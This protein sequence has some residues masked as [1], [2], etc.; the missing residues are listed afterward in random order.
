LF[1]ESIQCLPLSSKNTVFLPNYLNYKL[2][3]GNHYGT[4]GYLPHSDNIPIYWFDEDVFP[5]KGFVVNSRTYAVQETHG[6]E[7]SIL[8]DKLGAGELDSDNSDNRLKI[9]L[10]ADG[11]HPIKVS[12]WSKFSDIRL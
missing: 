3:L 6:D 10:G 2:R 12:L 1:T 5:R 7:Y 8:N 9:H 4:S 11:G